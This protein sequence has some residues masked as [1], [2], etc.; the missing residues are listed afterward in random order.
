MTKD[1]LQYDAMTGAP[2]ITP[3][4]PTHI[5]RAY[6]I[7]KER[8]ACTTLLCQMVLTYLMR[9]GERG[10]VAREISDYIA[11]EYGCTVAMQSLHNSLTNVMVAT[12]L[13]HRKHYNGKQTYRYYYTTTETTETT[14]KA[15]KAEKGTLSLSSKD[16]EVIQNILKQLK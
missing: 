2:I 1:R 6:V 3:T 8:H 7:L 9:A 13:A 10:G 14:E 4:R 12:G 15:E 5:G 16:V 11:T